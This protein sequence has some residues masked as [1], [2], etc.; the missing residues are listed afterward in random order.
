VRALARGC[1]ESWVAAGKDAQEQAN[2]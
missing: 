1:C 2:G